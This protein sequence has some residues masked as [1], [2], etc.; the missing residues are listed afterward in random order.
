[1]QCISDLFQFAQDAPKVGGSQ[2]AAL[3]LLRLD[4]LTIVCPG[5]ADYPLDDRVHVRGLAHFATPAA[6]PFNE[7]AATPQQKPE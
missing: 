6:L 7:D 4:S 3:G 5:N 1:M 2:R